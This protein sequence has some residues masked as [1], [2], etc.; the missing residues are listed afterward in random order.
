MSQPAPEPDEIVVNDDDDRFWDEN[1]SNDEYVY[2][3]NDHIMVNCN[4]HTLYGN[5]WH[6]GT[7]R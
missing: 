6:T 4:K 1:V 7:I 2:E 5:E 3:E